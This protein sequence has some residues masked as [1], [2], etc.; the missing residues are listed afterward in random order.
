[1]RRQQWIGAVYRG[2][3]PPTVHARIMR[4]SRRYND[5][6]TPEPGLP[7]PS[8]DYAV[9]MLD[10]ELTDPSD[11][12]V[13]RMLVSALG[14]VPM[15]TVVQLSSGEV[16]EVTRGSSGPLDK[17]KLKVVMD[18]RGGV[19]TN[20][21]EIDLGKP[22]P[23]E[24]PRHINR[25]VN[26]D[27]WKKGLEG[28]EQLTGNAGGG[29]D[30]PPPDSAPPPPAPVPMQAP[31]PA[32]VPA[33]SPPAQQAAP[34]PAWEPVQEAPRGHRAPIELDLSPAP[35]A[36]SAP[37]SPD[38]SGWGD[39]PEPKSSSGVSQ[40]GV[41]SSGISMGTSPS[42][43]GQAMGQFLEERPPQNEEQRTVMNQGFPP[44]GARTAAAPV[45]VRRPGAAPS[46][47]RMRPE[48]V[49]PT[50]E[51]ILSTTPLVHVLVYMLDHSLTGT[52]V[53]LEGEFEHAVYFVSGVPSR[54]RL[55]YGGIRLGEALARLEQIDPS[56][57]DALSAEAK[58]RGMLFGE[59]LVQEVGIPESVIGLGLE[60]Q[61]LENLAMLTN[62]PLESTYSYF[63]NV[64]SLENWG[65]GDIVLQGPLNAILTATRQWKDRSRI[66]ATLTR[67]AK[68]PLVFFDECDFESLVLTAE[69]ESVMAMLRTESITYEELVARNVVDEEVVNSLAYTFA[70]TRQFAFKGQKKGPMAALGTRPSTAKASISPPTRVQ[71]APKGARVGPPSLSGQ[72]VVPPS[73]SSQSR[74]VAA[75][76]VKPPTPAQPPA[77]APPSAAA[78][79]ANASGVKR[80]IIR[81]IRPTGA[82][83]AVS[84]P[85]SPAQVARP[86]PSAQAAPSAP[87]SRAPAV[88]AIPAKP[89]P[90]VPVLSDSDD[91][92]E[93]TAIAARPNFQAMRN[94]VNRS[95]AKPAV[96]ASP[97]SFASRPDSRQVDL[98]EVEIEEDGM[99]DAERALE[100]MTDFRL[101]EAALQ[102]GDL[103]SAEAL[104]EKAVEGDPGQSEYRALLVWVRS[105]GRPNE[106]SAFV[107]EFDLL[108]ADDPANERAHFYR[109]KLLKALGRAV[110]AL[111]GF[112]D[113]LA[114]NPQHREAATEVRVL[115]AR[116]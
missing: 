112:E 102:R 92:D 70:V 14:L 27:N 82:G 88:P 10:K 22:N 28:F 65:A 42:R 12:T 75:A 91:D 33:W 56:G 43:V 86:Q 68:H 78:A 20:G 74:Q 87:V 61:L 59:Y 24:A 17:P 93:K 13:L 67:I 29:S 79:A 5:L 48:G 50:A 53:F 97:T 111:A 19:V 44:K 106:L 84:P 80:P 21:P 32:P 98:D 52:V 81:P 63:Y 99:A 115:R 39:A 73:L 47:V 26:T 76:P 96:E 37:A 46:K 55:A 40:S 58:G 110:D 25:V 49:A 114:L 36:S 94:L 45:S 64:N 38:Y 109:A 41:S 104:S 31:P 6:L 57:L 100:A 105:Q 3:R 77:V 66:R 34:E 35:Q 11:R 85:V 18:A 72:G 108:L 89:L 60:L 103:A 113:V 8:S 62:L 116:R 107:G 71:A 90:K 54:V 30:Y 1:M 16:C 15:G 9:A 95:S 83:P 4:I 7:P 51:G 23:R 69:E 101:A 2:K